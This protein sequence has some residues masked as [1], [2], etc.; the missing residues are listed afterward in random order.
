MKKFA[1]AID[2]LFLL[3]FVGIGR[4]AHQHGIT[5]SGVASTLWPF[6]VGLLVGWLIVWRLHRRGS[7][8]GS[9]VLIVVATVAVGMVLRVVGG[10]G[11]ALA[12]IVVALTFLTLFLV[13]WRLLIRIVAR[14]G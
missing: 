2:L 14:R 4:N 9:G 7:L 12:F 5:I 11:T 8:P 1:L 6:L 13:G 3:L 10:Q